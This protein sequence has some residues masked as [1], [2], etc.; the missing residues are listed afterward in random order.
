MIACYDFDKKVENVRSSGDFEPGTLA[1]RFEV[2]VETFRDYTWRDRTVLAAKGDKR[3]QPYPLLGG[4]FFFR[5]THT[6]LRGYPKIPYYFDHTPSAMAV[7][8]AIAKFSGDS[9]LVFEQK[10]DGINIRLWDD[11]RT[12]QF[13]TR[14]VHDGNP[15]GKGNVDYGAVAE[16]IITRKCLGAFDLLDAGYTPVFEVVS[17]DFDHLYFK[18]QKDDAFLIDVIDSN[19]RLLSV[20]EKHMLAKK[21]GLSVPEIIKVG[22]QSTTVHQLEKNAAGM[23]YYSA[24]LGIEGM[25]A[26]LSPVIAEDLRD[27]VAFKI[28]QPNVLR[29][30]R[31]G[32]LQKKVHA[33]EFSG[34]ELN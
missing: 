5:D 17:P 29:F 1:R 9:M 27:Q 23:A 33:K 6:V 11:R 15:H 13:A 3:I 19:Q 2:P 24:Q 20:A 18:A 34:A 14:F 8:R 26:K 30:R 7:K 25:V 31:G 4:T 28:T 10:V 22:R 16:D 12:P 21:Y 32:H